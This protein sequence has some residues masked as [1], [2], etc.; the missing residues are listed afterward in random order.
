MDRAGKNPNNMTPPSPTFTAWRLDDE[1]IDD[2]D[3]CSTWIEADDRFPEPHHSYFAQLSERP[4]VQGHCRATWHDTTQC[5]LPVKQAGCV[6]NYWPGSRY[7]GRA[8]HKGSNLQSTLQCGS[9][10]PDL[11]SASIRTTK[12]AKILLWI[13]RYRTV[14]RLSAFR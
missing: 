14:V 1:T 7:S 2:W 13:V 3:G 4:H 8:R 6:W 12:V 9:G 5:K 11:S 10:R